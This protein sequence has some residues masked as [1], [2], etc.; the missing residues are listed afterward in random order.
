MLGPPAVR[1]FLASDFLVYLAATPF[2]AQI[3]SGRRFASSL[4]LPALLVALAMGTLPT[5]REPKLRVFGHDLGFRDWQLVLLRV[6]V[7]FSLT[8]LALQAVTRQRGA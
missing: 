1:L 7:V 8:S 4:C 3:S 2:H 6:L 5:L